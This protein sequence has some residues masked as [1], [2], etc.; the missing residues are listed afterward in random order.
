MQPAR[1]RAIVAAAVLALASGVSACATLAPNAGQGHSERLAETSAPLTADAML[2]LPARPGYPRNDTLIQ[3]V[4]GQYG[5]RRTAFQAV[6][7]LSPEQV[8]IV[9]TAPSGP[10]IMTID[11]TA[12]G[13]A[14]ERTS[15]A[16]EELSAINIL[17]D[18]F[19]TS[20]PSDA[21]AA[22]LP[23]GFQL[24]Y[25]GDARV[26]SGPEGP[27]VRIQQGAEIDGLHR[28]S[29]THLAFGYSLTIVTEVDR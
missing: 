26:V 9:L 15:L 25:D 23:H 1:L 11:W 17:G 12:A 10:R 19:L 13:V 22:A 20:W 5:D 14:V 16:P 24:R 21:I 29:F 27:V 3:T 18:V 28:A 6:L 8:T 4:V 2:N 7:E